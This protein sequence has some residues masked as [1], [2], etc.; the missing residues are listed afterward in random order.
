MDDH[1]RGNDDKRER[2]VAKFDYV[3]DDGDRN[4]KGSNNDFMR[5]L[6]TLVGGGHDLMAQRHIRSRSRGRRHGCIN[7]ASSYER[8]S[9]GDDSRS[10][11]V[12][13]SNRGFGRREITSNVIA[14]S[15][16]RRAGAQGRLAARGFAQLFSEE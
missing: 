11:D 7:S 8:K 16:P 10:E 12:R 15:I 1:G 13:I 4:H 5:N 6:C 3:H 2:D 14:R 9:S